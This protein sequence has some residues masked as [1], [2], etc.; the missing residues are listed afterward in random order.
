MGNGFE[1]LDIILLVMIAAFIFLRLRNVLGRRMGHEQTP[2]EDLSRKGFGKAEQSYKDDPADNVIPMNDDMEQDFK[3]ASKVSPPLAATLR[4]IHEIDRNF[5]PDVFPS[6]AEMAYE[7]I[8]L[9]FAN[10]DK[11]TLKDL[12]SEEVYKN[13]ANAIDA[14][15]LAGEEMTTDILSIKSSE[16]VDALLDGKD[17][18]VTV[19][20]ETEMISMTKDKEGVVISGDTHPHLV[21]EKWTFARNLKSR[22]PNWLLITTKRAD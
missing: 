18:E 2:R 11:K 8:V 22:N 19:R 10:G 13:F 15:E 4:Q 14:R 3:I 9:A 5:N 12:L 20:F 7:T 6:Q 21:R 17:A 1:F 16:L